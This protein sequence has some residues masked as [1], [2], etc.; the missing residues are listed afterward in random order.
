MRAFL[1]AEDEQESLKKTAEQRYRDSL[2]KKTLLQDMADIVEAV[3]KEDFQ[4]RQARRRNEIKPESEPEELHRDYYLEGPWAEQMTENYK[5]CFQYIQQLLRVQIDE[6]E[7]FEV[8]EESVSTLIS[9]RVSLWYTQTADFVPLISST[10]LQ[11]LDY[12]VEKI[13]NEAWRML[14]E[15]TGGQIYFAAEQRGSKQKV[16]I[17][18]SINFDGLEDIHA[19]KRLTPFDKRVYIAVSNLYKGGQSIVTLSKIHETMGNNTRP[20]STQLNRIAES[21]VKMQMA[22]ITLDNHE[23]IDAKYKYPLFRYDGQLLEARMMQT[24]NVHG[25]ITD[26]AVMI[27]HEPPLMEFAMGRKQVTTIKR[28]LLTSQINKTNANLAIEDYLIEFI[29]R[30]K[31]ERKTKRFT[32]LYNTMEEKLKAILTKDQIRRLPETVSR[33]LDHYKSQGYIT[34]YAQNNEKTGVS[35]WLS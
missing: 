22:H 23:E 28:D 1:A 8:S 27:L 25:I 31:R 30:Q 12:M 4:R 32:M 24:Y 35:I 26:S 19:V 11:K 33:Y 18:Y 5:N 13:N 16:T 6:M 15:D 34:G 14:E 3:E 29:A 21:I 2:N 20:S 9:S 17:Y 10:R 7:R